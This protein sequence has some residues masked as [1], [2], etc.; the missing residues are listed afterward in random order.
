M[1]AQPKTATLEQ[2]VTDYKNY[3]R[4]M[5]QAETEKNLLAAE[6]K[7]L[8]G[9]YGTTIVGQYKISWTTM[10]RTNIDS[11]RLKLEYPKIAELVSSTSTSDRLT[12]N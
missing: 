7:T 10:Q 8:L 5:E 9:D 12:V 2:L 6:I 1:E 4:I 3:Q 11:K